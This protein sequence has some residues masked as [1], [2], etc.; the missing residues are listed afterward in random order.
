MTTPTTL[1]IF[2]IQDFLNGAW[3]DRVGPV[4]GEWSL[5]V[6]P[7][8]THDTLEEAESYLSWFYAVNIYQQPLRITRI[9]INIKRTALA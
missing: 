6:D 8:W 7:R 9:D 2:V 5:D 4:G 1:S 3:R